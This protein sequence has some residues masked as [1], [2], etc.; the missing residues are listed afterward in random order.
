MQ[1]RLEP[2]TRSVLITGASSGIGEACATTLAGRGWQVLAGVRSDADADRLRDS[3]Q[4][5]VPLILDVTKPDQIAAAVEIATQHLGSDGLSGLVNNAGIATGGPL[6]Y[7][8][9]EQFRQAL[10][11]NVIGALAVTQAF[12]PLLRRGSGRIVNIS[13]I[14]GRIALP[15]IAPYA[16]SKHALEAMS[17]CLRVELS[18]WDIHVS[19]IEPGN[20]RTPIWKK[21]LA[22]AR[23]VRQA[24][25]EQ[26]E[27][28][29]GAALDALEA[30]I[31]K[32]QPLSSEDVAR[33]VAHALETQRPRARYP[34]GAAV[35]V[36]TWLDRLP[37]RWRDGVTRRALPKWGQQ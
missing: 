26:A 12:L 14:S 18:P 33:S 8:P 19:L 15:F 1:K 2:S 27:R 20:V 31:G 32:K 4:G 24:M 35:P 5:I 22:A 23:A 28:Y 6:E 10:E 37:T 30:E 16:A 29:Y 34:L 36:A 9:I 3:N 11:V 17:D 13:S 7:L 25:P 21:S